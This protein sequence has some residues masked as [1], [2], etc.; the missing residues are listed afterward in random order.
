VNQIL[1]LLYDGR[2]MHRSRLYDIV[3]VDRIGGGD[4]FTAGLIYGLLMGQAM[5]QTVEFAAAAS[6][7]K[8]TIP[9]DFNLV[10]IDEVKHLVE[11][12]EFGRIQW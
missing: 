10:S 5:E 2:E 12:K 4:A 7:L 11:G 9:G 6:C 8:H 3:V 1:G